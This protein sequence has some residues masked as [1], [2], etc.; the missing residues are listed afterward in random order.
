MPCCILAIL[1]FFGP[2]LVLLGIWLFNNP[3]M[4]AA[5]NSFL[6]QCLGFLFLPW[7]LLA[8]IFAYHIS[9][10]ADFMG[11]ST[12]GILIVIG[13]LVL[14]ILSYTGSGWGNRNRIRGYVG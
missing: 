12:T 2:R 9:P 13:G 3:Y 6:I 1:V 14:D 8:Y 10:G 4:S 7:M 11:L 5:V